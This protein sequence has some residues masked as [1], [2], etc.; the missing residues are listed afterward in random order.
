MRRPIIP[1]A[2]ILLAALPTAAAQTNQ[3][4]LEAEAER[5]AVMDKAKDSVLAVFTPTG[6]GGGSGVVISPDGFALTNFHVA[7]PSGN[8]MKCGMADGRIYDA[9]IVGLDPTGDIA[10]VKLF[11][12]DDFPHA[13]L[14]DS[15]QVQVGDW[16][17]AMGNP[18]LLATN[19]QPTV[20][21]GIV[22]GV[23]RYQYPAGTL[24]EYADCIQTDASI[25][26]GNS[27]GPLFDAAGRLIG[28]ATLGVLVGSNDGGHVVVTEILEQSDAYRRGLDYDDEIISFGGRTISTPN[29]FKNVLGIFPRG[30][31]VPLSFRREGNRYD[32][33]VRLRGVHGKA[34]LLEKA[35]GRPRNVPMPIPKPGEKPKPDEPK[36]GQ[37]PKPDGPRPKPRQIP[38]PRPG[39]RPPAQLNPRKVPMPEVVKKHFEAK[40]G[41]ANY[42]Y[43]RL[44]RDRVWKAWNARADFKALGGTWTLAGKLEGG[45]EFSFQLTDT[46][47][48][49]KVP[50]GESKWVASD[51]FGSSLAPPLSGGL[52]PA[53]NLW[54][55]LAV[56]GPE[57]FGEV[58]YLG[59][60]PVGG[61]QKLFDVLVGLYKGV[62]CHFLFD[63]AEGH[64]LA[65][66]M[67]PEEDVD[68]CEVYFSGYRDVEGRFLP[69]RMEVRVGD[70]PYGGVFNLDQFNFE[71]AEQE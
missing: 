36:P 31:R 58:T 48:L 47:G 68:P 15:D 13:E 63:P 56:V 33:L 64:L 41:F 71:K 59:T 37:K 32:V 53:L 35:A 70:D 34:E 52:L 30:W 57:N 5:I 2:V 18:F 21:Y 44:N 25:N 50:A 60:R 20:T 51:D 42:Y 22:S 54:R 8:A 26:P 39:G 46:D 9:V 17:F 24:L 12:R 27:G 69:A 45:G 28:I 1:A 14:G 61:H 7:K 11:G 62:E 29:G 16:C 40:R 3:T 55:R 38:I 49:L 67:F 6:R 10:L 66:E 23:H 65:L 4:V 43:N 19:L